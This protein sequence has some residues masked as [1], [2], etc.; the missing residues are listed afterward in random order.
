MTNTCTLPRFSKSKAQ[1]KDK[2]TDAA[3][4]SKTQ[5]QLIGVKK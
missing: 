1:G 5:A 3:F 2:S 4:D